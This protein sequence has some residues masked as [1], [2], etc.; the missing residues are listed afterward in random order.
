[1][2]IGLRQL[3]A[4]RRALW[5]MVAANAL[6]ACGGG[7]GGSDAAHAGPD[8]RQAIAEAVYAIG[9]AYPA[10]FYR[11]ADPYPDRQTL[12]VHVREAEVRATPPAVNFESCSNDFAQAMDW[13]AANAVSRG[14]VTNLTGNSETDWF[15][16]FDR[17]IVA[18]D[19]AMLVNRVFKCDQVDRSVLS[20]ERVGVLRSPD[21]GASELRWFSEYLW[22]FSPYNNA[23]HAVLES[24]T[25]QSAPA[26]H[27]IVRAEALRL[28]GAAG[29]D[30]IEVWQHDFELDATTGLVTTSERF[31]EVFEAKLSNGRATLCD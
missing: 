25:V 15:F 1:M 31:L 2:T 13:S 19:P 8:P 17:E 23:L 7:G 20:S 9:A 26:V 4:L 18:T 16:Q 14:Y 5:F 21:A 10:D 27:R 29:C 22:G 30:I 24:T 28:A 3:P 6:T 11:D 12:T